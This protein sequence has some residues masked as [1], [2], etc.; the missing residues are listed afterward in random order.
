[1]LNTTVT[2]TRWG[3]TTYRV[4][5]FMQLRSR[6]IVLGGIRQNPNERWMTQLTGI[7]SMISQRDWKMRLENE[8]CL[9]ASILLH[10]SRITAAWSC[11][12]K[13]SRSNVDA[14]IANYYE[15]S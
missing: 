9:D 12:G 10:L 1:M 7:L 11:Q 13:G 5:S 2:W 6:K 4:L 14:V 15:L 8:I 3:L